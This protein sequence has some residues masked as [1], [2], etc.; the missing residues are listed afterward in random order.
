MHNHGRKKSTAVLLLVLLLFTG[1]PARAEE[2]A[3][4]VCSKEEFDLL[5]ENPYG[6]FRLGSDIDMGGDY[7]PFTFYGELD[8]GG[9]TLYNLTVTEAGTDTRTTLD[10]NRK[11]YETSFAGLFSVLEN[12]SVYDV[13][14]AG[15]FVSVNAGSECFIA[16]LA[17]YARDSEIR[18]CR[19]EGRVY[20]ETTNAVSIGAGGLSGYMD[21]CTVS[22]VN[23]D[24][25]IA[26]ND[27]DKTTVSEEFIGGLFASGRGRINDCR[28]KLR[29]WAS[30]HGYVHN[31]GFAGM[32]FW[33][34]TGDDYK[35]RISRS[36]SDTK[37]TFFEDAPSRRAY[38]GAF[39]GENLGSNCY[40]GSCREEHFKKQEVRSYD[41]P[42]LPEACETPVIQ[43]TV[44]APSCE[45]WGYTDFL[46]ASCGHAYR[47]AYTQPCHDY[48]AFTVTEPGCETAGTKAHTCRG[49]G[50]TYL[51]EL[52]PLGHEEGETLTVTE[53]GYY[54]EGLA[55]TYC[56]RCEKPLH[57]QTLPALTPPALRILLNGQETAEITAEKGDTFQLSAGRECVS[58]ASSDPSVISV[59]PDGTVQVLAHGTAAVACSDGH[60][61][62]SVLI[63]APGL[64][65]RA[66]A[67]LISLYETAKEALS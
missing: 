23:V 26:V 35:Q 57:A 38:A 8:G 49:C 10:G 24:A 4:L 61:S 12:A 19:L 63:H 51:E 20:L 67:Y 7:V 45:R 59:S 50:D 6:K 1:M 36:V 31:G 65:E 43:Q 11:A 13:N 22:G 39:I 47:A 27:T 42:L 16:L 17:G 28:V 2:T 52:P 55:V 25:E 14:L 58:W 5:R 37:I 29:A 21:S 48:E 44:T 64:T 34:H 33:V 9:H 60:E 30:V 40:V 46:C 32:A 66:A 18:D 41:A 54:R 56:A 53:P 3:L 15:A 62:A